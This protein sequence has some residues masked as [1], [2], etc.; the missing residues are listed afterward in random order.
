MDTT[1]FNATVRQRPGMAVLELHGDINGAAEHALNAGYSAA[2]HADPGTILL[3]F[4]SVGYINSTGIALIVGLLA[5]SRTEQRAL[6]ACGLSA[7][8]EEIFQITRL[9]DFMRMFPDEDSAVSDQ[10]AA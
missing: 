9:A 8:Y 7:H 6:L 1:T 4:A 2:T 3:N 5:R 10:S